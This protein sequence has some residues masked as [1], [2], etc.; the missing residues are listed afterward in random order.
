MSL[1][2]LVTRSLELERQRQLAAEIAKRRAVDKFNRVLNE[3]GL[4]LT[5][6]EERISGVFH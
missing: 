2:A 5:G 1:G 4:L 3:A 6:I